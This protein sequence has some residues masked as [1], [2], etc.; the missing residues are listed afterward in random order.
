MIIFYKLYLC[1]TECFRKIMKAGTNFFVFLKNIYTQ[2]P[3]F[4]F[5]RAKKYIEFMIFYSKKI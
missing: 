1:M 3:K 4:I 2:T 5:L